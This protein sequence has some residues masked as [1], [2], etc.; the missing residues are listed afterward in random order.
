MNIKKSFNKRM[1]RNHLGV[2]LFVTGLVTAQLFCMAQGFLS[3]SE[4]FE[5]RV[6]RVHAQEPVV[7]DSVKPQTVIEGVTESK[8]QYAKRI[9]K[10]YTTL[11]FGEESVDMVDYIVTHEGNYDPEA[12]NPHSTAYG[13]FQFLDSTWKTVG[14]TKTSDI[15]EQ[16]SCGMKYIQN[17]YGTAK[18]AFLFRVLNGFY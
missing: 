10:E 18:E 1:S 4:T 13:M 3:T 5:Y 17:R 12:Q 15:V 14:C 7:N 11:Y 8:K 16:T 9:V 6:D 2:K